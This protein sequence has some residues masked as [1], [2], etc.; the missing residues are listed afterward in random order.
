MKECGDVI[1]AVESNWFVKEDIHEFSDVVQIN[2]FDA[3]EYWRNNPEGVWFLSQ[4]EWDY[5]MLLLR[6]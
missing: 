2:S 4:L 5:L 6:M 3:G 1:Q